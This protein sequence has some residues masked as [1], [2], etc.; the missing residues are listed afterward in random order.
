MDVIE[1]SLEVAHPLDAVWA[2]LATPHALGAWLGGTLDV[3]LRAGAKGTF[4]P[5]G[6]APR[7][8]SVLRVEPERELRFVWWYDDGDLGL[9][10]LAVDPADAGAVV[11]VREQRVGGYRSLLGLRASA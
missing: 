6:A 8:V 9:V 7:R 3:E 2:R 1:R 11:R 4:T 10:T 5:D